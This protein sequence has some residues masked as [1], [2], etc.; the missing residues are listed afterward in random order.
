MNEQLLESRLSIILFNYDKNFLTPLT[1]LQL[2]LLKEF[3]FEYT[4]DEIENALHRMEESTI[5]ED[6]KRSENIVEIEE[7][8]FNN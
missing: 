7:D 5:E 8:N 4:L 1:E 2:L 3:K 6:Y